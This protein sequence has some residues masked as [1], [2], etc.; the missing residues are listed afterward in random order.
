MAVGSPVEEK[1]MEK[2]TYSFGLAANMEPTEMKDW[3]CDA[4][5]NTRRP[6]TEAHTVGFGL[7]LCGDCSA[8]L[9][10]TFVAWRPVG[11]VTS[12]L[13]WAKA[14]AWAR[15][16]AQELIATGKVLVE[17]EVKEE[18]FDLTPVKAMYEKYGPSPDKAGTYAL[19]DRWGRVVSRGHRLAEVAGRYLKHK[20]TIAE[21]RAAVK[22]AKQTG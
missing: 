9:T 11:E 20:A 16:K 15:V 13:V 17:Y 22:A 6:R 4:C 14:K 7:C 10:A 1:K 19:L 18:T 12:D 2:R 8:E 3:D 21:L 5:F